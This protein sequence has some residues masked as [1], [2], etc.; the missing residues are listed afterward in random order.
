VATLFSDN[1]NR[2]NSSSLGSNWTENEPGGSWAITSNQL[3]RSGGGFTSAI[4]TTGAHAAVADC[5]ASITRVS[6]GWD[7]GPCVRATSTGA[8]MYY[9]DVYSTNTLE[10]YRRVSS[11]DT[12]VASRTQTHASGDTYRLEVSGTGATVTL[13][14]FRNGVQVGADISDANAA[15]ITAAGQTGLICWDVGTADDF[16]AEDLGGGG[17]QTITPNGI[18]SEEAFGTTKLNLAVAPSGIASLEALGAAIVQPGA[19][20]IT[21]NGVASLEAFGDPTLTSLFTVIANGIA[22]LEAFGDPTLLATYLIAPSGVASEEDFGDVV[23]S[24]GALSIA[25]NGIAS[26]EAFG[27][28]VFTPGGVVITP[29]GIASLE[30]VGD[31]LIS[32]GGFV[33]NANGIA[34]A[35]AF[36]S[37]T[38][39]PGGVNIIPGGIA[40]LEAFGAANVN[41]LID[42]LGIGSA[43]AFGLPDVQNLLFILVPQGIPS[44][45]AFGVLVVLGG[46]EPI[47]IRIDARSF[48]VS[49]EDT[50][51][52]QGA[53][54]EDHQTF[55]LPDIGMPIFGEEIPTQAIGDDFRV[56]RTYTDVPAGAVLTKAW[57]TVKKSLRMADADAL[58]HKEITTVESADG[59]IYE[60]N[61]D[62][63]IISMYFN[64][65]AA[66]TID[67]EPDV[68]Y[69]Y[70]IKIKDHLGLVH[71][72]EKGFIAFTRRAQEDVT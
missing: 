57:F 67:A 22:S 54:W 11:S 12:L 5:K 15:R 47:V 58:I 8:T 64:P 20:V 40:S 29:N 28:Q 17:T 16:L 30:A 24:I 39:S 13:K 23:L 66:E 59:H 1:F 65:S 51:T 25:V 71:T 63:G 38:F 56:G 19:V 49:W 33:I 43:E 44:A 2:A 27:S 21:P 10:L 36:G 6:S 26:A 53:G 37:H 3:V 41:H 45:E 32:A 42:A 52:I 18:A 31:A 60:A 7:G 55:S 69:E 70:G 68:L 72:L 61:S 35:E 4:T 62:D 48:T 9:L 46:G 14:I 34:S 50:R